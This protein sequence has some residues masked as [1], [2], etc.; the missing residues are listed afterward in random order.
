MSSLELLKL[1]SFFCFVAVFDLHFI[2][3]NSTGAAEKETGERESGGAQ[4][5]QGAARDGTA[6]ARLRGEGGP[7]TA[8]AL[9]AHGQQ[10]PPRRAQRTYQARGAGNA[11]YFVGARV[12]GRPIYK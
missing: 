6:R 9:P 5:G 2:L 3:K 11:L 4:P 8:A 12:R 7:G 1:S 10:G